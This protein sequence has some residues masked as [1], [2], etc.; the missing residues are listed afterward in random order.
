[1]FNLDSIFFLSWVITLIK[2]GALYTGPWIRIRC[3]SGIRVQTTL[4]PHGLDLDPSCVLCCVT[5]HRDRSS[6]AVVWSSRET[7]LKPNRG[8]GSSEMRFQCPCGE[9]HDEPK[10]F[11]IPLYF[12]ISCFGSTCIFEVKFRDKMYILV[13]NSVIFR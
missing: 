10:A 2:I 6:P 3:G 1:M 4:L 11:R 9:P 7:T 5:E 12:A 8:S 13:L